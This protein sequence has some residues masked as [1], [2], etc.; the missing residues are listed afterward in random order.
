MTQEQK[1]V[2]CIYHANCLDGMA[3]AWVVKHFFDNSGT[4][5]EFIPGTYGVAA[6][7]L[8][9]CLIYLVD[10]SY[11]RD[12]LLKLMEDNQVVLLDHHETAAKDL[13]GLF[14]IDQTHS[15]AMLAWKYFFGSQRPPVQLEY[16]QDRDLFQFKLTHT[17]AW[18]MAA[19]SYPIDFKHFDELMRR[20][21]QEMVA[22]GQVLIR[23]ENSDIGKFMPNVRRMKINGQDVPV[24]NAPYMYA[25]EIGALL[26]KDN[27]FAVV[28]NDSVD[29]RQ[30]SLRSRKDGGDHVNVVAEAFGGGGHMNAA[31][32]KIKFTDPRFLMSHLELNS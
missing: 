2:V 7:E 13:Q 27:D 1:K 20:P 18:T 19:F 30:F 22:E 10:F 6:P 26:A 31:G 8:K 5:V 25:S 14:E 23:K 3:S 29:E 16:V 21:V 11:K 17:K 9:D 12:V 32:F 28:Y 24:V 15:G 4:E